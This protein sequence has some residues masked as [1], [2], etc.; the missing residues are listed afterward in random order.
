MSLTRTRPLALAALALIL[1]A[2]PANASA[3]VK[4]AYYRL[5][6]DDPGAA[7]GNLGNNP[8]LDSFADHLDLGRVDSPRY[9]GDVPARAPYGSKLS[10]VLAN[11]GLGGPAFPGY[12]GRD[13]SVEMVSGGYAL[14]A[15]VKPGPTNLDAPTALDPSEHWLIAYNGDPNANG[16]GLFLH[17]NDLV[18]RIGAAGGPVEKTL[19]P[20]EVGAWHHVAYVQSLGTSG[21]YYDGKLVATSDKD[22]PPLT[23]S[24]GFWIGG[25]ADPLKDPG[26]YLFNGW[27]DEVRYQS[28]N[29]LSAGAFDP[30]AFLITPEPNTL[31][32]LLLTLTLL[33]PRRRR[34]RGPA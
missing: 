30:T 26:E 5:G 9:S 10:M 23:A 13:A 29:P 20:A 17:G 2:P 34:T 21:Y 32:A 11:I 14:E 24:G 15:W 16:F 7:P 1:S 25:H 27:I 18:A 31:A 4:G 33:C 12:Y 22:P 8:T 3:F 19:G 28:F 6:E